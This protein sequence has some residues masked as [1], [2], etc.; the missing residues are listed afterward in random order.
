MAAADLPRS[1]LDASLALVL[2]GGALG[3]GHRVLD[4]P[5]PWSTP[6][7]VVDSVPFPP[8]RSAELRPLSGSPRAAVRLG[9]AGDIMQ[10][11]LQGGD[12]FNR[13]YAGIA[14]L[15]R[16]FDLAEANLEFPVDTMAPIGPPARS[17][18]FNG[19]V[20]HLSALAAAG[21]DLVTTAN[22]HAWDQGR[23]G[24][25]STIAALRGRGL[26]PI[27]SAPGS[28]DSLVVPVVRDV[29]G[30]RIAFLGYTFPPNPRPGPDGSPEPIPRDAAVATLPFD[31]WTDEF[32]EAGRR[33]IAADVAAARRAGAEL[34]V[35]CVHWGREWR[36]PPTDDQRRAARDLV[37][38]GVD[39]VVGA[40]PHVLEPP[41]VYRGHL[42]AYSLGNV[43]SDFRPLTVRTG[44]ILDVTVERSERDV[45][46][47]GFAYHPI[48][49]TGP[50]HVAQLVHSGDP[51]ERG[52]AWAWARRAL[53]PEVAP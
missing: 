17:T 5:E 45:A 42:I 50:G 3:L 36:V 33:R 52:A 43:M 34:V 30:V 46:V 35:A 16:Q 14:P 47:T 40:H 18:V 48:L 31:N 28:G 32:R 6:I 20:A 11:R 9:F 25:A 10:H 7:R 13:S 21:F 29:G 37:D 38:S 41:E 49:V 15:V 22:N 27:G 19:S 24:I 23:R 1:L 2:V 44:A 53:G 8:A 26:V 12:D 4:P 51:G 39:L